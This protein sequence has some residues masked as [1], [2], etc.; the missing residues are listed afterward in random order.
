MTTFGK[1][2]ITLTEILISGEKYTTTHHPI[3]HKHSLHLCCPFYPTFVCKQ[4]G[5]VGWGG[6][7]GGRGGGGRVLRKG[8]VL[9]VSIYFLCVPLIYIFNNCTYRE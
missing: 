1:Y 7:G 2:I 9:I 6:W 8:D 3:Y 5:R 4:F